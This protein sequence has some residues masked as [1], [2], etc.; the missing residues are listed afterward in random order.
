MLTYT[1]VV[2]LR[3]GSEPA[4]LMQL[5]LH[6]STERSRCARPGDLSELNSVAAISHLLCQL[7]A[8]GMIEEY[9][10]VLELRHCLQVDVACLAES[11]LLLQRDCNSACRTSTAALPPVAK[12]NQCRR[13]TSVMRRA[14]R[15]QFLSLA[16]NARPHRGS[17][18]ELYAGA[19]RRHKYTEDRSDHFSRS[20]CQHKLRC[21]VRGRRTVSRRAAGLVSYGHS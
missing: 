5:Q 1:E 4:K 17:P 18:M 14:A 11:Y 10:V 15:R 6:R 8:R 2:A 16:C 7:T 13:S 12:R 9:A 20:L 21:V 3:P 19:Q